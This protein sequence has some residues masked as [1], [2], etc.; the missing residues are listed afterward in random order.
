MTTTTNAE[1]IERFN[2]LA[3]TW[4]DPEGPMWPLHELNKARAPFVAQTV[5]GHFGRSLVRRQPLAGLRVLDIGCGAGLLSEAMARSGASVIGVDPATRNISIARAH[6][7]ASGLNIDYRVGAVEDLDLPP[8]LTV[9]SLRVPQCHSNRL[10]GI[11]TTG[12][13]QRT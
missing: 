3:A 8:P 4:W 6:A 12:E 1:E 7:Q 11:N 5:A 13:T 9:E 2:A 10:E